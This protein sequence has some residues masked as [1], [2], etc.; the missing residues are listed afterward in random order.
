MA[1]AEKER[2]PIFCVYTILL[3]RERYDLNLRVAFAG[4]STP[5]PTLGHKSLRNLENS[6]ISCDSRRCLSRFTGDRGDAIKATSAD[7]ERSTDSNLRSLS[8]APEAPI[9]PFSLLVV[10]AVAVDLD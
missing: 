4:S 2:D 9:V 10:G 7:S 3:A 5:S 6:D 1:E 8:A